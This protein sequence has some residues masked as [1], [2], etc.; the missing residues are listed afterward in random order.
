MVTR[1]LQAVII[2]TSHAKQSENNKINRLESHETLANWRA[3]ADRNRREKNS[4][5]ETEET[6]QYTGQFQAETRKLEDNIPISSPKS[7]GFRVVTH[8]KVRV[9]VV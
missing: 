9:K 3:V 2:S 5:Q 6:R 1:E 8:N 7:Q 4:I